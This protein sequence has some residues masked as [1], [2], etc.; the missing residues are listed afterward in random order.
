VF[1]LHGL[2]HHQGRAALHV[3]AW[4]DRDLDDLA[5]HG[6][7]Q[8]AGRDID[9]LARGQ[10]VDQFE[11][12]RAVGGEDRELRT[13][14]RHRADGV[15]ALDVDADVAIGETQRPHEAAAGRQV[16]EI[17]VGL[18]GD[19]DLVDRAVAAQADLAMTLAV[20]APALGGAPG[21]P[22]IA[23]LQRGF[24]RDLLLV[25]R[26]LGAGDG[27]GVDQRLGRI[28]R[29]EIGAVALDEGG[30]EVGR[31]EGRMEGDRAQE[32]DIVA[33]TGDLTGRQG[34]AQLAYRREAILAPDRQLGDHGVIVDGNLVA[35]A[36]AGVDGTWGPASGQR[37]WAR[38]PV[39]GRKPRAG[40]SA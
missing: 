20:Q 38:R 16:E 33:E 39:A 21:R 28:G 29:Q 40:S 10:G 3:V 31:F 37:R 19:G 18:V 1:H 27:P 26:Q 35:G 23:G 22:G 24:P 36:D 4:L 7:R 5:G 6:R 25:Q 9:L 17:A 11:L 8:V 32:V 2:Q 13:D 34:G 15:A 12:G 14:A 30:V